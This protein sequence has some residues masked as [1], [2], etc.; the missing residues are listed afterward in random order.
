MAKATTSPPLAKRFEAVE[1]VL[2]AALKDPDT[3]FDMAAPA[4]MLD[5][6]SQSL[7]DETAEWAGYWRGPVR[8]VTVV[9]SY[10]GLA[11]GSSERW[12]TEYPPSRE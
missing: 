10:R 9:L 2:Q 8:G 1:A 11:H 7:P 5:V 12:G 4:S 3:Q 6:V